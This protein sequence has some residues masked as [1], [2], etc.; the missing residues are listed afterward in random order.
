MGYKV[1]IVDDD[2]SLLRLFEEYLS[3]EG[4]EVV[5]AVDG[6]DAIEVLK[7]RKF[8]LLVTD[9]KMPKMTGIELIKHCRQYQSDLPSVIVSGEGTVDEAAEAVNLGV[10][11]YLKKPLG[12]IDNLKNIIL[13]AI[14][15]GNKSLEKENER[16]K[17]EVEI[18]RKMLPNIYRLPFFKS[19]AAGISHNINSPLGGVI[20]YSQLGKMKNPNMEIF[21]T[22]GKQA[23]RISDLLIK[24]AE[25]GKSEVNLNIKQINFNK[26]I[27]DEVSFLS[28]NLTFKH[29]VEFKLDLDE[30]PPVSGVYQHFAHCLHHIIQNAR[31]AIA[32]KQEKKIGISL[33]H[34]DN[35]LVIKIIDNGDGIPP[36]NLPRL[37]EPGFT[38]KASPAE[39]EDTDIP[40]GYGVGLC[41]VKDILKQY[42]ASIDIA[43]DEKTTVTITIPIDN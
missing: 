11:Y 12:S 42:G 41:I 15:N 37:F 6:T 18:Y 1:L 8:D 25:K 35:S 10:F 34:I 43:A 2:L 39:V 24:I 40:T 17:K 36:E 30:V 23:Q 4:F 5:T 16:L 22:I 7:N 27:E 31:D 3:E 26:L 38:T 29:Q 21:D 32:E 33:K 14:E 20:G 13:E 9:I 28:F 19:L